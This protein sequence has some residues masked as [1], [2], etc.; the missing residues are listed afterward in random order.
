MHKQIIEKLKALIKDDSSIE[1]TEEVIGLTKDIEKLE[2]DHADVIE[3]SES[4]RK[5]YIESIKT[6]GFPKTQN[7]EQEESKDLNAIL[8]EIVK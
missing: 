7:E 2:K 1:F 3:I 8:L 4:Y 5:K 6:T